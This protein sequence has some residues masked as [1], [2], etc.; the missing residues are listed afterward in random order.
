MGARQYEPTLGRFTSEDPI[1]AFIGQGQSLNRAAYVLDNPVNRYD[2]TGLFSV[3]DITDPV[4]DFVDAQV[5]CVAHVGSCTTEAVDYWAHSD[6]PAA[7]V[8]GPLATAGDLVTHPGRVDDYLKGC[9]AGQIAAGTILTEL[10]VLGLASATHLGAEALE[11][12]AWEQQ[13]GQ[14]G[15]AISHGGLG[16]GA[17]LGGPYLSATAC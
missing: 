6:S 5:N 11:A 7:D 4:G 2:L 9:N 13:L 15:A 10:S 14:T 8:F 12:T 17:L 3:S 16:I 1:L